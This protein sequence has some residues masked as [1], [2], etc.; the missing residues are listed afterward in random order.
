MAAPTPADLQAL[1]DAE[2]VQLRIDV[3]QERARRDELSS[4][5]VDIDAL[6]QRFVDHGGDKTKIKNPQSYERNPNAG[7]KNPKV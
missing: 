7:P 5:P 2:L 4:L 1:T 6:I 3:A